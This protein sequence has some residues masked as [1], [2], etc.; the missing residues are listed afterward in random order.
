MNGDVVRLGVI[1]VPHVAPSSHRDVLLYH[2][3]ITYYI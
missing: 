2:V 3:N 1:V